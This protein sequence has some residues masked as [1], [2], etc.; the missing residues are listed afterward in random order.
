MYSAV[1]IQPAA[2]ILLWGPPGC[3]KTL[4]AKAVA[5]ESK[6]NFI[7]IKGPELL[8]KYVGE[9]ERAVRQLFS[10]AKSS[11]PCIL[12]FDEM[13]ALVPKRD[14]S[15]SDASSRVVNALLT[16][17][18]GV[19]DRSGIYVIGATN[20]PDI[21]DEAIRRPG[22]FSTST[23]MSAFPRLAE[24]VAILQTLY[25]HAPS[26]SPRTRR[27]NSATRHSDRSWSASPW[28]AGARATPARTSAIS[29][30]RPLSRRCGGCMR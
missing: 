9:S 7:S 4:V 6:A 10:R 8:N 18:D 14:D 17:L 21:I 15:L 2:G 23:T 24:R 30:R 25:R 28:T 27:L 16:E 29:C 11:A 26:R 5:N 22:R 12:F 3:G 19:G 13:D 1:G 20:R